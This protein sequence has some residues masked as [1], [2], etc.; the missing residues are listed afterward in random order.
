MTIYNLRSNAHYN[1]Y[2]GLSDGKSQILA[3]CYSNTLIIV[4]FDL[5][6]NLLNLV[7]K[8]AVTMSGTKDS[9]EE[10]QTWLAQ[11]NFRPIAITIKE[12]F[13]AEY[14]I[15]IKNLPTDFEYFLENQTVFSGQDKL[16]YHKNITDWKARNEFVLWWG[17]DF[18]CDKNGWIIAS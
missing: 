17:N 7:E 3:G 14:R 9:E 4:M 18:W 10:L 6:G 16:D 5:E 13:L 12:F 11:M 15:G 8:P 1:I 2:A